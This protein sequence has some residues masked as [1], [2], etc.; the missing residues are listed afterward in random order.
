MTSVQL[1]PVI[2]EVPERV[3]PRLVL[4]VARKVLREAVRDRWFWLYC[5]GFAVLAGVLATVAVPDR[6]I[7]GAGGFGRTASSLVA[8]VQLVVTLMALTLGARSL[9]AE[10]E[11]GTLRF[12]M[13]HPVS[14]TEVLLGTW[15]GLAGSLLAAVAGG[16]GVAGL[17]GAAQATPADAAVL[18]R[19]AFYSWLLALAMLGLGMVITVSIRRVGAAIG[20]ALFV[21][22]VLVFLG[23]LGLMGTV[24]A[25]RLPVETL[26]ASVMA[27]PVEAFRLAAVVSLDGSLD[28]LGPAG[29]YAVDTYGEGIGGIAAG[30]LAAW[31][32]LPLVVAWM[33]FRRRVDL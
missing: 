27:N 4:A 15:A 29:T 6:A 28:A 8:L 21:W 24:V 5:A 12:L 2:R 17:M 16:F 33:L 1:A 22:L 31:V 11:S 23:D 26:F 14:R 10:R 32:V 20:T 13:S 9:A 19:I 3:E 30:V 25:T 7:T 18:V